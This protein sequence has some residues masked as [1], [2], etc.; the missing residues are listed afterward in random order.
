MV[1]VTVMVAGSAPQS[2]VMV[3]PTVAAARSASSVQLPGVPSPTTWSGLDVA[4]GA[5]ASHV[6]GGAPPVPALP[7]VP[8]LPAVP[9]APALP[10]AP[11]EPEAPPL[12]GEPPFWF[13]PVSAPVPEV[14]PLLVPP[15]SSPLA[16]PA[17]S[18]EDELPES[19]HATTTRATRK[20]SARMAS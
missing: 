5:I 7:E 19:A 15:P 6:A 8:A 13:P 10:D 3:P 9:E 11:L 12:A 20:K 17:P 1:S 16:P 18:F 4:T 14:P 2:N